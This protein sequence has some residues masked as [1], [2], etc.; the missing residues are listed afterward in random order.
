M[1]PPGLAAPRGSS[2]S[3]AAFPLTSEPELSVPPLSLALFTPFQSFV[4]SAQLGSCHAGLFPSGLAD[5][6]EFAYRGAAHSSFCTLERSTRQH[7]HTRSGA[8]GH[9][10]AHPLGP[11][12]RAQARL[13]GATCRSCGRKAPTTLF[14]SPFAQSVKPTAA[15]VT[16]CSFVGCPWVLGCLF[17]RAGIGAGKE[18]P[19]PLACP[20]LPELTAVL[21]LKTPSLYSPPNPYLEHRLPEGRSVVLT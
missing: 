16:L 21:V 4:I 20:S 1:P 19:V 10:A 6:A 8:R 2:C 13:C 3:C 9:T 12:A 18:S 15:E 5:R 7:G 17:Q 11:P 14:R